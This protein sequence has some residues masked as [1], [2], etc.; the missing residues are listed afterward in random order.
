VVV[1]IP[2]IVITLGLGADDRVSR[3]GPS[4]VSLAF[5]FSFICLVTRLRSSQSTHLA[6]V[7]GD[8]FTNSFLGIWIICC[9]V[10]LYAYA[11]VMSWPGLD[12][13][14]IQRQAGASTSLF[15]GYIQTYFSNV[16]SPGLIAIG[17]TKRKKGLIAFGIVGCLIM[18]MIAAQRTV[19]MLPIVIICLHF[20]L[21]RKEKA[22]K[23]IVHINDGI[24]IS[25]FPGVYILCGQHRG[26]FS[27]DISYF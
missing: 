5:G 16:L 1:Y 15:M 4:L 6:A 25:C 13:I 17:L 19:F 8:S 23:S 18:Y 10:L 7:P 14:Y 2:T 24:R 26:F 21:N 3:Y 11:S 22:F 9:I 12:E 20:L 27:L